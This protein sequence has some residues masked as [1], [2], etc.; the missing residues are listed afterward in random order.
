MQNPSLSGRNALKIALDG[1]D[2][3]VFQDAATIRIGKAETDPA[4][5]VPGIRLR[6]GS[7]YKLTFIARADRDGTIARVR[8]ENA[9]EGELACLAPRVFSL[10]GQKR[11]YSCDYR[12]PAR[13]C[14]MHGYGCCSLGEETPSWWTGT[15]KSVR[16][17]RGRG[18]PGVYDQLDGRKAD[19]TDSV[20]SNRPG[21]PRTADPRIDRRYRAK[22]PRRPSSRACRTANPGFR[23]RRHDRQPSS[24]KRSFSGVSHLGHTFIGKTRR[25]RRPSRVCHRFDWRR[26]K[27]GGPRESDSRHNRSVLGSVR[28][29]RKRL[30][31]SASACTIGAPMDSPTETG[32]LGVAATSGGSRQLSVC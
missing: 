28:P 18:R 23:Y 13:M 14:P 26:M 16:R 21:R 11:E 1:E 19:A 24:R 9:V 4:P 20:G 15:L 31:E 12:M 30:K 17:R 25:S 5:Q 8:F 7:K 32:N 3:S 29:V 6:T 22:G 27:F 2:V 10:D